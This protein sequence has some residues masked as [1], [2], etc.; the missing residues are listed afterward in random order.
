M[1]LPE[2]TC[3]YGRRCS[4][5]DPCLQHR[6]CAMGCPSCTPGHHCGCDPNHPRRAAGNPERVKGED[7]RWRDA[8]PAPQPTQGGVVEVEGR[9]ELRAEPFD[10]GAT[11]PDG[12]HERYPVLSAEERAK[13]FVRPV[14]R[15][16]VHEKCGTKTTMGLALCETYARDPSFYGSTFCAGCRAHFPVGEHGEF[17]WHGTN[18]KVGT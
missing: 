15:A 9:Q 4:G 11:K 17:V 7:G 18:L 14:Y 1:S 10:Y 13:G 8:P 3:D 12:Q 16:Y 6:Y 5:A 2:E